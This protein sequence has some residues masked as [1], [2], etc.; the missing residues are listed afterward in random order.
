MARRR[1]H[2]T[3]YKGQQFRSRH[4]A[5]YAAFFDELRWSWVYEPFDLYGWVPD[6]LIY[7]DCEFLVE[8]KPS[9]SAHDIIRTCVSKLDL[10]EPDQLVLLLGASPAVSIVYNHHAPDRHCFHQGRWERDGA[11]FAVVSEWAS[12]PSSLEGPAS[13][14]VDTLAYV[15]YLFRVAGNS[16]QWNRRG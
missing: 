1:A 14:Y 12:M 4:E 5:K 7:G 15:E 13:D 2:P 6:F 9:A 16:V 10:A 3:V 8:I 11:R